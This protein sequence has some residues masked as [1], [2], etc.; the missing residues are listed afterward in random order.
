MREA[1][2]RTLLTQLWAAGARVRAYDP[3]AQ[4][5][6]ARLF[7]TRADLTLCSSAHDAVT[8]AD[9]LIIVTEWKQFRSPD[10]A[11]LACSLGDR[12]LFDGRNLYA[13]A[14]VEAAGLTYYGIGRGRR[15]WQAVSKTCAAEPSNGDLSMHAGLP[16][17]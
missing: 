5:E 3:E 16:Q 7:G 6:A 2:S 9:A 11:K 10:F 8:G 1:P 14:E 15:T 12:T 4:T 13:P 17:V